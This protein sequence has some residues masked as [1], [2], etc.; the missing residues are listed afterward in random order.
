M[1]MVIN[2]QWTPDENLTVDGHFVRPSSA[3]GGEIN[4]AIVMSMESEPGRFHLIAS[5]SCQ[6]SHRCLIARALKGLALRIPMHLAHG[7]RVEGY[8]MNDGLCWTVPGTRQTIRHLHQLYSL[9]V[10]G[11][12]GRSTV[13][14][15]WDSVERRIVSNDSEA[16]FDA[17]YALSSTTPGPADQLSVASPD[18]NDK[19]LLAQIYDGVSNA[20]YQ[21]GFATTQTAYDEAVERVFSTLDAF[22]NTLSECRYLKGFTV[23][24]ADWFLFPTLVRFDS[25]YHVLHRCCRRRLVDYPNLWAYARDLYSWPGVSDTVDFPTIRDASYRNDCAGN[26]NRI[27]AI[28][29]D[30]DWKMSHDRDRLAAARVWGAGMGDA[31]E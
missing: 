26:P 19:A 28:A 6:W 9:G 25:V 16:I 22:E 10:P 3:L 13:P 11:Y 12:N 7:E 30:V 1:G 4:G 29:P 2:G 18:S 20:V 31:R 14:V 21:A 17:F 23:S 24:K 15:L 27:V 8:A 5:A